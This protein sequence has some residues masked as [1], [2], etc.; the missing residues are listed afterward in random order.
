MKKIWT[1]FLII[2]GFIVN[3]G[4]V[5]FV[6]N[7]VPNG[8]G[9]SWS[10]PL[11]SFVSALA[12]ANP[13][14]EIWIKKGVYSFTNS[15]T[16]NKAVHIY[17]GF[18]GDESL[19]E[20]R[21]NIT[22]LDS[23]VL[24]SSNGI[25]NLQIT[26]LTNEIVLN[27]IQISGVQSGNEALRIYNT[28]SNVSITNC[29]IGYNNVRGLSIIDAS[30]VL[31]MCK[32][33]ENTINSGYGAGIQITGSS[34]PVFNHS[35]ITYNTNS[36]NIAGGV[37]ISTDTKISGP[38][39]Y[40]CNFINNF[41]ENAAGAIYLKS[42]GR[43]LLDNCIVGSNRHRSGTVAG[44]A[45]YID[46]NPTNGT[47]VDMI[48]RNETVI[49][50][51]WCNW[52]SATPVFL[53]GITTQNA[54]YSSEDG[55]LIDLGADARFTK[56][57]I[58]AEL[59][60][61]MVPAMESGVPSPGRI[62]K[63]QFDDYLGTGVYH[64]LYLPPDWE[65]DKK[66]PVIM[67][68]PGNP[69][70]HK[71]G[72]ISSGN[73]ES[74]PIG[75]GI[76]RGKG[77]I[78]VGLPL[79][80]DNTNTHTTWFGSVNVTAD[81]IK[82]VAVDL[83]ENF[84]A[85]HSAFFITGYSRGAMGA[86]FFSRYDEELNDIWSGFLTYDG[87]DD[88]LYYANINSMAWN[89]NSGALEFDAVSQRHERIKGRPT[90]ML[91]AGYY[92]T[93]RFQ[94]HNEAYNY[95]VEYYKNPYRNH[96]PHWSVCD[97]PITQKAREW[98]QRTINEKTGTYTL[99]GIVTD[100]SGTPVSGARVQTGLTHFV[101]TDANGSYSI[102]GL[103]AGERSV[104]VYENQGDAVPVVTQAIAL[105]ADVANYNLTIPKKLILNP[106]ADAYV[107]GGNYADNNYGTASTLQVK[108][109][110]Y[111]GYDRMSFLKFDLSTIS[112]NVSIAKIRIKV[113]REDPDASH[114]LHLV[115]NSWNEASITWNNMPAA[116]T[117]IASKAA[118]AVNDWIEFDVTSAVNNTA[119]DNLS[120]RISD[121]NAA[122]DY[123]EYHSKET[124]NSE[125]RPQLVYLLDTTP[126]P[127]SHTLT[128]N[129]DGMVRQTQA[130]GYYTSALIEQ[131]NASSWGRKGLFSF[132]ISGFNEELAGASFQV[133]LNKSSSSTFNNQ[134]M[135]Y[136]VNED[137]FTCGVTTWD[138][139]QAISFI[140]TG[141]L[142]NVDESLLGT[143]LSFDVSDYLN[144][145]INE[146]QAN[147]VLC[148]DG[149]SA[150]HVL[151]YNAMESTENRPKLLF[152]SQPDGFP[153]DIIQSKLDEQKLVIYPNPSNGTFYIENPLD[154]KDTYA[155]YDSSGRLIRQSNIEAFE[156]EKVSSL[157]PGF[158]V[159]AVDGQ[160]QKVIVR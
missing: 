33:T 12:A 95:P 75:Y 67:D 96:S 134:V 155:I 28:N 30:P 119:G 15:I 105:N 19:I 61:V 82:R 144:H 156:T 50:D 117:L 29:V 6:D 81:Y 55:V 127:E 91:G 125:D 26:G 45:V 25:A 9:S 42:T 92:G 113:K 3:A 89:Y 21:T 34:N 139:L 160:F 159:I 130:D 49:T 124:A 76:S 148:L 93:W 157:M 86:H 38:E 40:T 151:Y 90:F 57:D 36:D 5:I 10:S 143:Y 32:I 142:V 111:A 146:G 44:G 140:E 149:S 115:T 56:P 135:V 108:E 53:S 141:A 51:N 71:W 83:C 104:S 137:D 74:S 122:E 131:K 126:V 24:Y 4:N 150:S 37:Y 128:P 123:I 20:E 103:I 84:G 129:C 62:V 118:P 154:K 46:G 7:S 147:M 80:D 31:T 1:F 107:K 16:I 97:L 114:N 85:D 99:S 138:N 121:M 22:T 41:T 52:D 87:T 64:N 73:P 77:C 14:D 88:H 68:I 13:G 100:F 43:C 48:L 17:G 23:T 58:K 59:Y 2:P 70:K 69:F 136:G 133:F 94:E 112:G 101:Y 47:N 152:A 132:D 39:F 72:D 65:A 8:D 60:D 63:V 158:Y 35:V 110:T 106:V 18:S 66:Y 153:T 145:C 109:S 11:N 27:G 78:L 120:V 54:T 116:S 98:L 79:I 102:D